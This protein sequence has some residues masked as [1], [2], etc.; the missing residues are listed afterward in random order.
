[1]WV[2]FNNA[3]VSAVQDRHN[4]DRLCVRARKREHLE[5]LFPN[6]EIITIPSRDYACRVFVTKPQFAELLARR[7]GEIDYPNFKNSVCED[8]LHDLYA[9]FWDL[10][11]SYQESG[12][13]L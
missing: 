11:W 8:G 6:A 9:D 4:P 3:F 2:C 7:V 12:S 5:R 1:M 13:R 10:H